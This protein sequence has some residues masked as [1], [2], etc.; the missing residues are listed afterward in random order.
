MPHKFGSR[1]RGD[2]SQ[3][4]LKGEIGQKE[5]QVKTR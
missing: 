1:E 2:M 3:G 5:F 4:L